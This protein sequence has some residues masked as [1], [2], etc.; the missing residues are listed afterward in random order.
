VGLP[1]PDADVLWWIADETISTDCDCSNNI[2]LSHVHCSAIFTYGEFEY[3]R[4][5]MGSAKK[6]MSRLQQD[7]IVSLELHPRQPGC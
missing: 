7:M 5:T 3:K 4:Q 6:N 2:Q 1:Q